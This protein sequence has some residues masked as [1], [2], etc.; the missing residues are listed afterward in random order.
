MGNLFLTILLTVVLFIIFKLFSKYAIHTFYAVVI[1][2]VTCVLVGFLYVADFNS[3]Q[4]IDFSATWVH[5]SFF[6][7]LLFIGT[8]YLIGLTVDKIS[9][10]VAT[11]SN[12]MS[13]VIPVLANYLVFGTASSVG[14][15]KVAGIIA[16]LASIIFASYK[17]E[18][19]RLKVFNPFYFVLP[20]LVFLLGGLIDSLINYTNLN[21]LPPG[22]E[23][24]FS[25]FTF[26]SAALAG[27]SVMLFKMTQKEFPAKKDILGGI[28]LG[29][30]N[31]F[32]IYFLLKTLSDFHNDGS[33]VFPIVNI[34]IILATA[35]SSFLFFS[36]R[37]SKINLLGLILAIISIILV[38]L[39]EN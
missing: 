38:F 5:L 26:L 27:I 16:G 37:M 14:W 33:V 3:F 39:T 25:L 1:N 35:L 11:I 15:S 6:I 21:Y 34:S 7:G 4:Q 17:K 29:I 12:K 31:Y 32:S 18:D 20:I 13:L 19:K 28:L 8:F 30:P 22:K 23:A 24:F 10:T 2:Y 9:M 36:E